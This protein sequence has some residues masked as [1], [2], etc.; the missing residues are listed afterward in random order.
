[1]IEEGGSAK[2]INQ[3]TKRKIVQRAKD[4]ANAAKWNLD[5]AVFSF[6]LIIIIFVLSFERVSVWIT[7]FAAVLGLAT[8]WLIG[9]R[10]ARQQ[11]AGFL[12]EE[13]A[14]CSDDWKDYYE[15][16][17]IGPSAEF[18]AISE[19]YELL[20]KRVHDGLPYVLKQMPSY[21]LLKDDVEEAYKVLS[22]PISRIEYDRVFWL[23]S[24]AANKVLEESAKREIIN[25][26]LSTRRRISK[27]TRRIV[28][29]IPL[30]NKITRPVVIVAGAA[31][32]AVFLGGTS[33]AFAEPG[34]PL[35]AP[36]RGTAI[37]V[38]EISSRA[39][40]LLQDI[41]GIAAVSERRVISTMLQ[42]MRVEENLK[43]VPVVTVSTNDLAVFPS[44][45]HA[46][47][48]D[49]TDKRYSQFRYTVNSKGIVDVD[50]SW[51]V[52]DAFLDRLMQTLDRLEKEDR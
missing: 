40:G 25:T 18:T 35:A 23:R 11:Y 29:R 17:H 5:V 32:I 49:Y 12:D 3:K 37:V 7:A 21:V 45:E 52:T 30:L 15:I 34:H 28:V 22:N 20:H 10:R 31:L 6:G 4:R 46:L 38:T 16:L 2:W 33:I 39:V 27:I 36:F 8:I 13:L 24:N 50:T 14:K 41:R 9:W 43:E 47:F 44:P 42:S 51:A 19:A 26:S 48:P 1:M